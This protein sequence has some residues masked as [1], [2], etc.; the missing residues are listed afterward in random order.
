MTRTIF[1]IISLLYCLILSAQT[2]NPL[3][4]GRKIT[5]PVV[6]HV[7]YNN[8]QENISDELIFKELEDLNLDFSAKND[9]SLLVDDF[10]NIVGNPNIQFDLLDTIFETGGT[11]GI[12]RIS[13][14]N[15]QSSTSL[16]INKKNCLNVFIAR[17]IN[18]SGILSDRVNLNYSGVGI[19]EHTLTHE[20]GHWLGLYHIFGTIKNTAWF[21]VLFG[22]SDDHIDDTPK[23]KGATAKCYSIKPD[24]P[25][26]PT[27]THY[28]GNKTLYNN[29]M[30]YNPCRCM[31]TIDQSAEMRKNIIESKQIVFDHSAK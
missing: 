23:Q 6:F 18:S 24:C 28:K 26:P 22:K 21:R 11:P 5:I 2:K 3:D 7:I 29:F 13:S 10:K 9:M 19:N 20:T 4:D 27:K 16:L 15:V 31:F 14:R 30:D 8:D 17:H 12:R 1:C 25:C